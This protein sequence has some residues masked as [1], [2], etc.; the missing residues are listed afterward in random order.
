MQVALAAEGDRQQCKQRRRAMASSQDD[1]EEREPS[2]GTATTA[3]QAAW[4]A[5]LAAATVTYTRGK[6]T[7]ALD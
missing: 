3:R 5:C 1:K 4:H 7:L 6:R 2:F